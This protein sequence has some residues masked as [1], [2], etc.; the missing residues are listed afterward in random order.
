VKIKDYKVFKSLLHAF[1]GA[2]INGSKEL[3]FHNRLGLSFISSAMLSM[4]E[5]ENELETTLGNFCGLISK[6]IVSK[7]RGLFCCMK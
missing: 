1:V 7:T 3:P 5:T 2:G 6:C 4:I